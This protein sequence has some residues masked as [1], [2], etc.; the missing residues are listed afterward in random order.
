MTSEEKRAR[1]I[2]AEAERSANMP[3]PP[4][5]RGKARSNWAA[6]AP[7]RPPRKFPGRR[8]PKPAADGSGA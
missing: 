3:Q 1:I 2:A 6:S 5:G 7:V 4:F 8:G